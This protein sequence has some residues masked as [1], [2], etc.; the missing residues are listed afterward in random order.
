MF[1]IEVPNNLELIA[2]DNNRNYLLFIHT[3]FCGTCNLARKMLSSLEEVW[4]EDMFMDVNA[5][6]HPEIMEHYRVESVPC[7]LVIKES[8]C[9]EKIYAFQSVPYLYEIV[10]KYF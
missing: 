1:M 10:K 2:D 6:L 3:P 8:E 7:L 9:V 5:S 4:G